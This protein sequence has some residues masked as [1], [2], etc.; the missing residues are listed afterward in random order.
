MIKSYSID[1]GSWDTKNNT[2]GD[3][4]KEEII[5]RYM[6]LSKTLKEGDKN[7][8]WIM[9]SYTK[10][11]EACNY[12]DQLFKKVLYDIDKKSVILEDDGGN[13]INYYFYNRFKKGGE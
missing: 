13:N 11:L 3:V 5:R 8:I 12:S 2:W 9:G 10:F 4:C 6:E 1:V 7:Y